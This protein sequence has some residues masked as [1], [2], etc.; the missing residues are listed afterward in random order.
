[1]KLKQAIE[2]AK[3]AMECLD[4]TIKEAQEV[5]KEQ[6]EHV[7]QIDWSTV[8]RDSVI[9]VA[10]CAELR[11]FRCYDAEND[12]ISYYPSGKSSKTSVDSMSAVWTDRVCV[13]LIER[14]TPNPFKRWDTAKKDILPPNVS[15]QDIVS[16]IRRDG[17]VLTKEARNFIWSNE[18][19]KPESV[20]A[21]Y[22]TSE[23]IMKLIETK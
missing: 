17:F 2:Q 23:D 6:A 7:E 21:A 1:M 11:H 9:K 22:A 19:V 4:K 16:I 8:E 13:K 12:R 18:L 5:E 20:I 15:G 10:H 14:N 3:R